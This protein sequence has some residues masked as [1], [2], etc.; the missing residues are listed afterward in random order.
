MAVYTERAV[1]SFRG[2]YCSYSTAPATATTSAEQRRPNER[3]H[4]EEVS[5]LPL[6]IRKAVRVWDA[7]GA[8]E[9]QMPARCQAV[10]DA[11]GRHT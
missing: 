2:S 6:V 10:I 11:E 7:I 9:L 1:T 8:K 4:H 3:L 5:G